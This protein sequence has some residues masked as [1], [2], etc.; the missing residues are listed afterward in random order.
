[1]FSGLKV[2]WAIN[3]FFTE[4]WNLCHKLS[5]RKHGTLGSD[6]VAVHLIRTP[7]AQEF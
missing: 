3:R 4:Q 6:I 2:G 7:G 5:S 1:M